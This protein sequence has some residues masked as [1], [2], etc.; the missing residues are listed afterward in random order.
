MVISLGSDHAGYELKNLIISFLTEG[1]L[2]VIDS[3]CYDNNPVDYPDIAH[4]TIGYLIDGKADFAI[5][6]CGTGNGM[7]MS[8]NRWRGVRA[9]LC[10]DTEIAELS[11]QHNNSNVLCIPARFIDPY[12]SLEMVEIFLRTE[13]E[14]GRH[15]KRVDKINP[16]MF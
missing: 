14:G 2:D 7:C 5:L 16:S 11:R 12:K 9:A 1:G 8:A 6:I 10:W 4:E 3:G 13:F 15:E